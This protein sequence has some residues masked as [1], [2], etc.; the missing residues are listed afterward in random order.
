MI[1]FLSFSRCDMHLKEHPQ[2]ISLIL[3]LWIMP[4]IST[5]CL[6]SIDSQTSPV[7][8]LTNGRFSFSM[9]PAACPSSHRLFPPLAA[10]ISVSSGLG[11]SGFGSHWGASM[12]LS[13]G[14]IAHG[15]ATFSPVEL[16]NT[17]S[18]NTFWVGSYVTVH[19][20]YDPRGLAT[21]FP[22]TKA[23]TSM[24]RIIRFP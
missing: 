1:G 14:Y 5:Y 11:G 22:Y 6:N 7:S 10:P 9:G 20:L 4:V 15:S 24:Y 17:A 2:V 16:A 3:F 19:W 12:H 13:K 21:K 8:S 23:V 18:Q